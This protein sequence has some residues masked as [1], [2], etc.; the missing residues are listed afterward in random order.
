[1][2]LI[3]CSFA[4]TNQIFEWK[5]EKK[6]E[7]AFIFLLDVTYKEI[8]LFGFLF[9]L[10]DCWFYNWQPENTK[11]KDSNVDSLR[12][13]AG[14]HNGKQMLE[15]NDVRSSQKGEAKEHS[16]TPNNTAS[17]DLSLKPE[18]KRKYNPDQPADTKMKYSCKDALPLVIGQSNKKILGDSDLKTT[19]E[20]IEEHNSTQT[21]RDFILGSSSKLEGNRTDHGKEVK[22]L[23]ALPLHPKLNCGLQHSKLWE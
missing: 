21:V 15:K 4:S 2:M 5:V 16:S 6:R 9:H 11:A 20:E 23:P 12:L 22:V 10:V 7:E 18:R 14:H 19:S 13:A 1:M 17:Q 8:H 3:I